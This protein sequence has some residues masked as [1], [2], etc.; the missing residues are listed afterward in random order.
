[1]M[2]LGFHTNILIHGHCIKNLQVDSFERLVP[3]KFSTVLIL[4]LLGGTLLV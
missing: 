2:Q 1:M 4:D 3:L